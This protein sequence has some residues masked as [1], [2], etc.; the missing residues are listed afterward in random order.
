M[1]KKQKEKQMEASWHSSGVQFC[2]ISQLSYLNLNVI[3]KG[4]CVASATYSHAFLPW[5]LLSIELVTVWRGGGQGRAIDDGNLYMF[6]F[7]FPPPNM[8][9][10]GWQLHN[11]RPYTCFEEV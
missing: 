3:L 2:G 1:E 6:L 11:R 5:R 7:S 9:D 8:C 4:K 10:N